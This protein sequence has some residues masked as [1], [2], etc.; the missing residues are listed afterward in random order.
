MSEKDNS[1]KRPRLS[2]RAANALML[3]QLIDTVSGGYASEAFDILTEDERQ[4]I[5][6]AGL[7]GASQQAKAD[8]D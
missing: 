6:N 8:A 5:A 1:G 3:A 4:E 7:Q 2:R